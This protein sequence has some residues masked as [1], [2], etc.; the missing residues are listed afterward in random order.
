LVVGKTKITTVELKALDRRGKLR[1]SHETF[2][3]ELQRLGVTLTEHLGGK[4]N[5]E[6][7]N[8]EGVITLPILGGIKQYKIKSHHFFQW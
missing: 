2:Q 6:Q 7:K 4:K 1:V 8:T 3:R 5:G